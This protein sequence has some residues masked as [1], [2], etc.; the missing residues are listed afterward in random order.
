M[1][2]LSQYYRYKGNIF[3]ECSLP[4]EGFFCRK[5]QITKKMTLAG[6]SQRGHIYKGDYTAVMH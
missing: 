4:Y 6:F 2:L 5:Q 1:T 3:T